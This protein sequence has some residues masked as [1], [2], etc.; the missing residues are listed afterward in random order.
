MDIKRN[1]W[2]PSGD[3]VAHDG[4]PVR[5]NADFFIPPPAE[6]GTVITAES[7]LNQEDNPPSAAALGSREKVIMIITVA[8]SLTTAAT[9]FIAWASKS[10][11]MTLSTIAMLFGLLVV[12][13]GI[14]FFLVTRIQSDMR[15]RALPWCS[16]VGA[17]GLAHYCLNGCIDDGVTSEILLFKEADTLSA[18]RT[19][20]YHNGIYTGSTYDFRWCDTQGEVVLAEEGRYNEKSKKFTSL[21]RYIYLQSAEIQWSEHRFE[22]MKAEFERDGYVEFVIDAK[23]AIRIGPGYVEFAWPKDTHRVPVEEFKDMSIHEGMFSFKH[24]DSSWL[25]SKGKFNFEY[26][27][28]PNATLF[29]EALD[30]LAGI[31]FSCNE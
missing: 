2:K 27:R 14:A 7:K 12:V 20:N 17:D 21:H 16:Y 8:L 18:R 19:R 26:G 30:Q 11:P 10:G 24:R 3:I 29:L 5:G 31:S 6:I 25:G 4:Q 9:L 28:L 15:A 22:R 13:G 23:H 1:A